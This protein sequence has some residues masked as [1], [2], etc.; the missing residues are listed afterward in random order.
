MLVATWAGSAILGHLLGKR[1]AVDS[2]VQVTEVGGLSS[3]NLAVTRCLATPS[4]R[5]FVKQH[6][7]HHLHISRFNQV[8]RDGDSLLRVVAK[9]RSA[10]GSV[11]T[12]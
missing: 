6:L 7:L 5:D 2:L 1:S 3:P 10:D 11:E 12:K 8:P 9:A 4:M